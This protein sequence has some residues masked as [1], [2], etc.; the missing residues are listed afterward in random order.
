MNDSKVRFVNFVLASF[1][2]TLA[3][4]YRTM[5]PFV[6]LEIVVHENLLKDETIILLNVAECCVI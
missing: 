3:C 1:V 5:V 6:V 2:F 4:C